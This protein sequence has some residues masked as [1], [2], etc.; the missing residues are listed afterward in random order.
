MRRLA[1]GLPSPPHGVERPPASSVWLIGVP[2]ETSILQVISVPAIPVNML[3]RRG[4]ARY[5]QRLDGGCVTRQ[6]AARIA[7]RLVHDASFHLHV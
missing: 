1:H 7:A 2:P 4:G 3:K 6:C 5:R